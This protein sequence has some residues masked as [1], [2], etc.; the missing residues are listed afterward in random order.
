NVNEVARLDFK[1][2]IGNIASETVQVTAT[3][4][5]I[6]KSTSFIGT[7]VDN[8]QIENLPLNGRNFTQ[9][10]TLTPGV[11]RGTPGSVASGE[12]GNAET[13]RYGESGGGA[14][15]VNGL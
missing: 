4:P 9:L 11:T 8:K 1:L 15:S 5:V 2:E 13:F 10:T 3:A 6:E 12:S 14:I 7:V